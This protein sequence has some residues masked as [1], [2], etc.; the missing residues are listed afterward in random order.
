MP[1]S[2]QDWLISEGFKIGDGEFI[3]DDIKIPFTDI[4]GYS[5]G[6]FKEKAFRRGWMKPPNAGVGK[7]LPYIGII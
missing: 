1:Q 5:V 3:K 4:I 2:I 6:S 7:S